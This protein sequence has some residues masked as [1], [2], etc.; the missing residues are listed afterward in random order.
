MTTRLLLLTSDATLPDELVDAL[1]RRCREGGEI[2]A[3]LLLP[4]CPTPNAW[5]WD[6]AATRS[7]TMRRLDAALERLR[8]TGAHVTGTIGCDR[9]PMV[10]VNWAMEREHFDEVIVVHPG[11][12]RRLRMD[13]AARIRRAFN[14][15]VTH[16]NSPSTTAA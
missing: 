2:E 7:E 3:R 11:R 15:P 1:E 4:I 14:V 8:K 5:E 6:E 10:C 12:A 13:L 16:V 9:D